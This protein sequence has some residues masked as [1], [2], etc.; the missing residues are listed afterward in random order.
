LAIAGLWC[1]GSRLQLAAEVNE[2]LIQEWSDEQIVALSYDRQST[3]TIYPKQN[4][5]IFHDSTVMKTNSGEVFG[6]ITDYELK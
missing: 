1:W 5:V 3:L 6:G 4:R 2:F